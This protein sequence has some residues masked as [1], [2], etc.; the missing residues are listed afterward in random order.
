MAA[1]LPQLY[2]LALTD[3]GLETDLIFNHGIDLPCFAAVVLLRTAEGRAALEAYYTPYLE[4]ARRLGTAFVLE[5]PTWR[6]SPDWAEPLGIDQQELDALNT[7][8]IGLMRNLKAR[9]ATDS[10]RIV[11]SGC[12]GPRGDGYDP[13]QV[14]S[15][16]EA[17]SYHT[18]QARVLGAAGADMISAITMTNANEATGVAR[19]A[20]ATGLPAVISFT[21]ETDGRLPTGDPLETAIT[22]V[23]EATGAYPAYYMVNCAHPDHFASVLQGDEPWLDRIRGIRANASRCSHEELNAMTELDAG[24]PGELGRLYRDVLRRNPRITVLG[25]CCGTDIRHVTAVAEACAA[26]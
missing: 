2:R 4:L 10:S 8:A 24:D 19:A 22:T 25:G 14:M 6:A 17:A 26:G 11:V 5:S 12:I 20:Q 3:G 7:S 13:G 23:D 18:H 16:D 1:H 15:P 9:Y 21:V